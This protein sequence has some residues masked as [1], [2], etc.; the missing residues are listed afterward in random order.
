MQ[1]TRFSGSF[2]SKRSV[3][4]VPFFEHSLQD[5]CISPLVLPF[6][7]RRQV[8]KLNKARVTKTFSSGDQTSQPHLFPGTT[9]Q[10]LK[11]RAKGKGASFRDHWRWLQISRKG[12]GLRCRK[13]RRKIMT[14]KLFQF[15]LPLSAIKTSNIKKKEKKLQNKPWTWDTPRNSSYPPHTANETHSL[16]RTEEHR[17]IT[18]HINVTVPASAKSPIKVLGH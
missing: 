7:R 11:L 8:I 10:H 4:R 9:W 5:P 6:K 13:N 12:S 1:S 16:K 14:T 2:M 3:L 18:P 15:F 17:N